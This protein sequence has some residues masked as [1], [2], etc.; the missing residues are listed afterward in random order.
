MTLDIMVPPID[1]LPEISRIPIF[2]RVGWAHA[3]FVPN[4][5]DM[6]CLKN[7]GRKSVAQPTGLR[8]LHVRSYACFHTPCLRV[9]A[10]VRA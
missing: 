2:S 10:A 5:F 6:S 3:V 8:A 7:V 9:S 4:N 1:K